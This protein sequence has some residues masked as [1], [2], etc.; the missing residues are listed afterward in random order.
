MLAF[1]FVLLL[2]ASTLKRTS[3]GGLDQS[4]TLRSLKRLAEVFS[5]CSERVQSKHPLHSIT[6][7]LEIALQRYGFLEPSVVNDMVAAQDQAM[8]GFDMG[9][10]PFGM[11]AFAEHENLLSFPSDCFHGDF[12]DVENL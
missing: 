11:T 6:K 8:F 10:D 5:V 1:S 7:S 9:S 12:W 3:C 2:K 4:D